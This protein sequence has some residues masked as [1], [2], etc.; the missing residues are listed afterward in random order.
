MGEAQVIEGTTE[1]IMARLRDAYPEQNLR[2]TVEPQEEDLL[3]GM[4][5]PS[6]TIRNEAHLIALLKEGL[7]GTRH[8]VT[9]ETWKQRTAEVRRR[10][11]QL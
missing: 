6:G 10:V 11:N 1:E 5:P 7:S 3:A 8:E 9:D 4:P 2:V